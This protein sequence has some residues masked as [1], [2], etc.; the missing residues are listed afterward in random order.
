MLLAEGMFHQQEQDLLHA[1]QLSQI[2]LSGLAHQAILGIKQTTDAVQH[3]P[4]DVLRR[5]ASTQHGKGQ[6]EFIM[7]N[8]GKPTTSCLVCRLSAADGH[9]KNRACNRAW[10]SVSG[11][12]TTCM[13]PQPVKAPAT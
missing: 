13:S 3:T 2:L 8:G 5:T 12:L 7:Q 4:E 1:K 10:A 9:E 11:D 6:V